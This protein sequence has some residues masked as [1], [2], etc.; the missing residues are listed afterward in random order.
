MLVSEFLGVAPRSV[1]GSASE[2]LVKAVV[3]QRA[4]K[5]AEEVA[6]IERAVAVSV[7]M[8]EAGMR[9]ARPGVTELAIAAE[10]ERI[11]RAEGGRLAYPVIGT[12][13]GQT[14]H[15]HGYPGTL[16]AGD[17]YLLDAGA[18]TELGYAGDLT[19]TC[20]V[21]ATFTDRQRTIYELMLSA[22]DASVSTLAPGV[23]NRDVH[24]AAAR[25]IFEGMKDLGIMKGDTDA[26]LAAGG[27]RPGAS[28]T[29]SG[30]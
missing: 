22:Y 5:A 9:L 20:P 24:F 15:N 7:A 21:S 3:E 12:V 28:P 4:H 1:A 27:A 29:A 13:N 18:E 23:P 8:H 19:S 14:L 30:T 10:V 16:A 11:A 25:V 17:L 26:A 2:R 6:E